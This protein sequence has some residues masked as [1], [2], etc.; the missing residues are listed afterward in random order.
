MAPSLLLPLTAVLLL[1]CLTCSGETIVVALNKASG[2][3]RLVTSPAFDPLPLLASILDG[4]E[5]EE[6]GVASADAPTGSH[7]PVPPHNLS[8][9]DSPYMRDRG[10]V[11]VHSR[12][13][14]HTASIL[15]HLSHHPQIAFAETAD[16]DIGGIGAMDPSVSSAPLVNWGLDRVDARVPATLDGR[17]TLHPDMAGEG[18]DA[19]VVDTGIRPDHVEF[20]VGGVG[21]SR[22]LSALGLDLVGGDG[23]LE[24]AC[25]GHGTFVASQLAGRTFGVAKAA[26]LIPVRVIRC[27][28]RFSVAVVLRGL[29]H[30]LVTAARRGRA[31]VINL[32]GRAFGPSQSLDLAAAAVADAGIPFVVASGNEGGA[33]ACKYSPN[34]RSQQPDELPIVVGATRMSD[35]RPPLSSPVPAGPAFAFA[36]TPPQH[37]ELAAFSNVGSCVDISAPGQGL[38]G[39]SRVCPTCTTVLSGTSFSTPLVA[40]VVAGIKALY[41]HWSAAC[42]RR[43]LLVLATDGAVVPPPAWSDGSSSSSAVLASMTTRR[44]LYSAPQGRAEVPLV[45][46]AA[47]PPMEPPTASPSASPSPSPP[48]SLSPPATTPRPPFPIS[49]GGTSSCR[50]VQFPS[51]EV[52]AV[53]GGNG[54]SGVAGGS[55]PPSP[56][57]FPHPRRLLEGGDG[58]DGDGKGGDGGDGDPLTSPLAV[59]VL[60]SSP[61]VALAVLSAMRKRGGLAAP[62]PP[63][64]PRPSPMR[65]TT[66]VPLVIHLPNSGLGVV[67]SGVPLPS[68]ADG[69]KG[70]GLVDVPLHDEGVTTG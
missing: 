22:V 23:G 11:L 8:N 37:D 30:A 38:L 17:F 60:A 2:S 46:P 18:V 70:E 45:C 58:G 50:R 52:R 61:L 15:S 48:A 47:L 20:L 5:G 44:L 21:P 27:D 19:Y 13:S 31:S 14:S 24:D 9:F 12:S 54:I 51:G 62:A 53:C 42:V 25:H 59:L 41:P 43:A 32:S 7:S 66:L 68:T 35:G 57:P 29:D 34:T 33:D 56:P 40:G 49:P 10:L 39:A 16:R 4:V 65:S 36:R 1:Q 26:S 28:G 69:A 64:P 6:G 3:R 63:S 55:S 67:V